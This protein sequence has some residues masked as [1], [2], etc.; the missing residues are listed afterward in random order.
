VAEVNTQL[1]RVPVF[2]IITYI[3]FAALLGSPLFGETLTAVERAGNDWVYASTEGEGM[4]VSSDEGKTWRNRSAGLPVKQVWPFGGDTYRRITDIATDADNRLRAAVT[5]STGLY[6]TE[7]G[8][9]RWH[10]IALDH[11]VK[12]SNYFTSVAFDSRRGLIY[13][14]TSFN[15]LFVSSDDGQSWEKL[16]DYLKPIYQGAGFY[17]EITDISVRSGNGTVYLLNSFDQRIYVYTPGEGIHDRI[18]IPEDT[19]Y[20]EGI[21]EYRGKGEKGPAFELHGRRTRLIYSIEKGQWRSLPPLLLKPRRG[22]DRS[23]RIGSDGKRAIYLN[24]YNAYGSRLETHLDFLESHDFNAVVVDVKDDW[25]MLTYSSQL[26]RHTRYGAVRGLF[27]LKTLVKKAHERGIE[28]IGRMV[29][30]KD[31]LLYHAEDYEYAVWDPRSGD[32]WGHEV[33][34]KNPDTGETEYVQREFWV[35]PFSEE[36]W[37]YNIAIAEE[38]QALGIDEVQFDYIRFPSDGEVSGIEYRHRRRGM[39]KPEAIE[40]FLKKVRETVHIPIS[41]DLYG[42]NSWYRM[43]NWI[44]QDIEMLSHYVDVICPMYYPSHFPSSFLPELSY[45]ERAYR[46]YNEGTS[47]ART[48]TEGRS[49]IRPYV[50]AFLMGG[51]LSMEQHEYERYLN[52]QIEGTYRGGGSGYTLWNN[53]NRYYMVNSRV[54]ALNDERSKEPETDT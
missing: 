7:N 42:F 5:T 22:D 21:S 18:D 38:L 30:F 28:V 51:E 11:P 19:T 25:G 4:L 35:D 50:Q 17:K 26:E 20:I 9:E 29:I 53:M 33:E 48:I 46:I 44:G 45:I 14:G 43:G 3:L 2:G 32:P 8:G 34:R 13:L 15:G 54:A 47:R 16:G 39:T 52:R 6:L 49:S 41:A 40:S 10:E 1:R 36:V 31:K 27:D 12:S 37:D 23:D 24:A